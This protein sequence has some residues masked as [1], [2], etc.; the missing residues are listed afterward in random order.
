MSA[1]DL[2]D[3]APLAA[4]L[5]AADPADPAA[6]PAVAAALADAVRA[7]RRVLKSGNTGY[8]LRAAE[9]LT[10]VWAAR[11]RHRAAMRRT[12]AL[13]IRAR[14]VSDGRGTPALCDRDQTAAARPSLT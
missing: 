1:T 6:G 4:A 9:M 3:L 2:P 13:S 8:V 12:E 11:L 5:R 10:K 14:S 7:L